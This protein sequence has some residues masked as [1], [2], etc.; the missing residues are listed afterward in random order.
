MDTSLI[1]AIISPVLITVGG[2]I[3][4][5]IKSRKEELLALE[6]RAREHKLK[7]YEMLL[8]P[9]IGAFTFTLTPEEKD[10]FYQKMHTV[11]Y[12]QAAINLISFG[13]DE[14]VR[15]YNK[16]MQDFFNPPINKS[17]ENKEEYALLHLKNFADF[18]L[19]IRK[20]LYDKRSNLKRSETLEFM[21]TDVEKH[22]KIF[23]K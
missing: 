22:R 8:E 18:L 14:V 15:S 12:R 13:S 5:L 4:W 2:L 20:D 23:D 16:I 1:I 19:N 11:E 9:F 17:G 21:I 3:S 7:T 6:E 10:K